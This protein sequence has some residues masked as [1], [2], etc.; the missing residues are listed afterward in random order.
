MR[1]FQLP[2]KALPLFIT[3]PGIHADIFP[4]KTLKAN[5][6]V[7]T[8]TCAYKFH[9]FNREKKKKTTFWSSSSLRFSETDAALINVEAG[10]TLKQPAK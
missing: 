8:D 9:Y 1:D 10:H 7:Q 6:F 3:P 4:L 5:I 2:G